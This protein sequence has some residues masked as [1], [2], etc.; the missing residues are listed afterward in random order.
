MAQIYG[1]IESLKQIRNILDSKGIDRF[2][3]LHEFDAFLENY[4]LEKAAIYQHFEKEL[5]ID[6]FLLE[7]DIKYKYTSIE[8]TKCESNE[9]LETKNNLTLER[10][11]FYKKINKNTFF[12]KQYT[13]FA[14]KL[15]GAKM[16]FI[17]YYHKLTLPYSINKIA[18]Q[19]EKDRELLIKYIENKYSIIEE[20]SKAKIEELEITKEVVLGLNLLIAGAVGENLVVREI[21]KLSDDYILINDFS[22]SFTPPIYNRRNNDRIFSIQIDHLLI[23]KAG[24]FILETKNWSKESI[25]SL[26]I[27]SPIKQVSRSNYAL[28]VLLNSR[29]SSRQ[30]N[31]NTHHWGDKQI[32]I[33]SVVVMINQKPD[34]KFKHV[35]VKT[36]NE[37]N[38]YI[39]FFDPIF[40]DEEF[41]I[42]KDEIIEM[43]N[44]NS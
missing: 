8:K 14:L 27:R 38:S 37:L 24:L 10:S 33:R 13:R 2:N 6:I 9:R 12:S 28:F 31:L 3:S 39:K 15:L 22:M 36:L 30:I 29:N 1:Q 11:V 44:T 19:I 17:R 25:Q 20:R 26:D 40:T 43:N 21:E 41:S 4:E 32:P 16:K 42:I 23:S 34:V 7:E 18:K 5:D 35:K